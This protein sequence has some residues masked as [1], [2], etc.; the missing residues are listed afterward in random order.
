MRHP[1]ELESELI[2]AFPTHLATKGGVAAATQTQKGAKDRVTV[3]PEATDPPLRRHIQRVPAQHQR[4]LARGEGRVPLP[5]VLE[6][7]VPGAAAD[8]AWQWVFPAARKYD[9]DP[10]ARDRRRFHLH[11]SVVQRAV[12]DAVR[13]A[14]IAKRATCHTF[15]HSFA[16][17]LLEDGYD[18]RTVQELLGHR[19]VATTMIYTHVL[20]QGAF[21][22]RSPADSLVRELGTARQRVAGG[23]VMARLLADRL[24]GGRGSFVKGGRDGVRPD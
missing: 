24:G 14:G 3:L 20:D 7:K 11:P 10:G 19:D 16:T 18:V 23:K 17:H 2:G 9:H 4:D 8:W 6:R 12:R 22:V 5:G 15:R 1:A 13:R 21:G